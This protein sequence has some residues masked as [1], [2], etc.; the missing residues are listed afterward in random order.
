[1]PLETAPVVPS[2]LRHWGR[3]SG[4]VSVTQTAVYAPLKP[5]LP[6]KLVAIVRRP[7][8]ARVEGQNER[9]WLTRIVVA[10]NRAAVEIVVPSG[11][12]NTSC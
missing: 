9:P 11:V 1:M 2:A 4:T 12:R 7:V 6:H 5:D 3:D 10:R 8:A